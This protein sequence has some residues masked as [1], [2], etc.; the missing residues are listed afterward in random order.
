MEVKPGY[1]QTE[2]GVIPSDW[3]VAT[4]ETL[5][6]A[7]IQN[8]VFNEPSRKG[9]GSKLIN[10]VDLYGSFPINT[11]GLDRFDATQDEIVRF[12]VRDGDIFFTRS[13]LTPQ[14][15]AQCNIFRA[16]GDETI[17]FDCHIIRVRP[18]AG[19]T[20][21]FFL[22][23]YCMSRP[24]R[25]FLVTNAKTTTM[26]TIDQSV[27]AKLPVALP[28]I[29]EQRAI[30]KS[31][32]DVD[33]FLSGLERLIAKKR[34]LK[35]STMQQ[36]LT[37]QTRLPGFQGEWEVKKLGE[38]FEI[39]S[40]KRVF[41]KEWRFDGIPFYRARELAVLAQAGVV[42]NEIFISRELYDRHRRAYGVPRIGDMLVTGVG[43]L[44]KAYVVSDEH[45]FYF[46][47]GNI[48]WFKIEGKMSAEFLRQ[49]YLTDAVVKQ[50]A[51]GGAG[52]TVG[53]YTISAAKK[54]TISFPS[55]AEQAAIA[56]VLSDMDAEIAA[57]EQRREKTRALKQAMMQ[58][59][60]TGKRRLI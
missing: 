48:L 44:G 45:E 4:M 5:L 10:V 27:I 19:K 21:P 57:L 55:R 29:L 11:D 51:E 54:T 8:G 49:L 28:T 17:V 7:P 53:T 2:V 36:L 31:L 50:V 23:R 9:K 6:V 13:S 37:G 40:S 16:G 15:I 39:T 41:Q 20:E 25:R 56:E 60:L 58:E 26:T 30:A 3:D 32:S 24:A 12:G 34:D 38:L 59:L 47:D 14:G 42:D 33:A 1:K 18:K 22:A 43:T 35:R 52:T 46:K